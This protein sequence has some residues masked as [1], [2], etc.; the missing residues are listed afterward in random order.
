M[1]LR[2]LCSKKRSMDT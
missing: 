1:D 2:F